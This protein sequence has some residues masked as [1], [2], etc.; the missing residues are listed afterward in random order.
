MIR[1]DS[2]LEDAFIGSFSMMAALGG[3]L[4]PSAFVVAYTNEANLTLCCFK[5]RSHTVVVIKEVVHRVR[6]CEVLVP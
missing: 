6:L 5:F 1:G 4:L 2:V 3:S